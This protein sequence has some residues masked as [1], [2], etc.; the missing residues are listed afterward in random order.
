MRKYLHLILLLLIVN[1]YKAQYSITSAA[2][3]SLGDI[4]AYDRL[5]TITLFHGTSG[6]NQTWNYSAITISLVC[7]NHTTY[8]PV[9]IVP[10]YTMYPTANL[11]TDAAIGNKAMLNV[12][13]TKIDIVGHAGFSVASSFSYPN[14]LTLITLPFSYG[15]NYIDSYTASA[16]SYTAS[17]TFTHV[18][19]GY[20]TLQLP[21]IT[22]Y[23]V[24]KTTE[25]LVQTSFDGI[26]TGNLRRHTTKYYSAIS[27][28]PLLV[29]HT[30]TNVA[31]GGGLMQSCHITGTLYKNYINAAI[32]YSEKLKT[33]EIYPNPARNEISLIPYDS[34]LI[35][36]EV[37]I[38]NG[39]GQTVK[40]CSIDNQFTGNKITIPI[41][42]LSS[43]IYYV[44]VTSDKEPRIKKIIIE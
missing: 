35:I 36:Q 31:T 13:G 11:A 44:K 9:S 20:G 34:N 23:N 22:L 8:V 16:P 40:S 38:V 39:L 43:G 14:P 30:V 29:I 32:E 33:F 41:S 25:D 4:D 6:S 3:P 26:M 7:V 10:T 21:S 42:D 2:N 17:G 27:K 19:D 24:L 1:F 5:D 12:S 37:S 18:A 28:F 15:S